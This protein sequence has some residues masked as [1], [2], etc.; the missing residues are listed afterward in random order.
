[1]CNILPW[2]PAGLYL[3]DS[4]LR[5]TDIPSHMDEKIEIRENLRQEG[6]VEETL[7]RL[8]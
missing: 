1:M 6:L 4:A 7:T 2:R 5:F 3:Q 8:L